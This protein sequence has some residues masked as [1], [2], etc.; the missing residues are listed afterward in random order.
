M[1][2]RVHTKPVN[3]R[4]SPDVIAAAQV[5]AQREGMSLS[6]YLRAAIRNQ[7]RPAA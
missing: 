2:G 4:I 7:L 1:R 5:A 6:E 3:F